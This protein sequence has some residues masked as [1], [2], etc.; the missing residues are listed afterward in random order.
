MSF[1]VIAFVYFMV[2]M[3]LV[4]A[5]KEKNTFSGN[6]MIILL[7]PAIVLAIIIRFLAK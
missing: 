1:W 5:N 3:S 2:G 4:L 7:W 6:F